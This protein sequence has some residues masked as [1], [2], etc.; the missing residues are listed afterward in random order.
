[1]ISNYNIIDVILFSDSLL[2]IRKKLELVRKDSF[3]SNDRIVIKQDIVDSYPYIDA[4]GSKLI[5]IQKIINQVDISNCFILLVTSNPYVQSEIE[6]IT[7]F[8]SVDTTPINFSIT[9]GEYKKQIG[10]YNNTACSKLWNHLY[11]GTD[12]NINPCCLADHRFPIIK[13]I[14]NNDV[15]SIIH[16]EE[17]NQYRDWMKQGYRSIACNK[18]YHNEDNNIRSARVVCDPNKEKIDI[19]SLDIRINNICNFKCRMCSEYFSSSIQQE[20][21]ELYGKNSQLG[22]E[23]NLLTGFSSDKKNR[24]LEKIMPYITNDLTYIY[25]AGGEPLITKEHYQILD[26]LIEIK[27]LNLEISYNTNLS[28]LKY[29]KFDVVDYWK[30]F[31]N[32]KIGAS[33]DASDNV[34]EYIRHGTVWT[35]IVK[36]IDVIKK[37]A[38]NVNLFISSTVSF[39]TIEN[40]IKLQTKWI[41]EKTFEATNLTLHVLTSP[42]YLSPAALPQH[43]KQRLSNIIEN[44]INWLGKTEVANQWQDV[45]KYMNNNDYAYTLNDFK[46]RT[47]ILDKHRN[48]SFLDVFPEFRDLYV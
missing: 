8:Y 24:L 33:I 30:Q 10:H 32:V 35:D 14:D 6:F 38:P 15:V 21:I 2:S 20:T 7:K 17:F 12:G 40:L 42:A 4:P 31:T 18:C 34:A 41:S 16:S 29:K 25:F 28:M 26:R 22:F 3:D 37:N 43:H 39:L 45:L 19:T 47:K 23:K 11:V 9:T 5:E 44:H 13:N 46:S 36:N 1:M 48:E 27:N